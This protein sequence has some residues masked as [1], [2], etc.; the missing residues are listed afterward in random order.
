MP[1]GLLMSFNSKT[2]ELAVN[3]TSSM[4]GLLPDARDGHR[5]AFYRRARLQTAVKVGR[6][7]ANLDHRQGHGTTLVSSIYQSSG[8]RLRAASEGTRSQAVAA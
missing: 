2:D 5:H 7:I 3:V 8:T 1:I 4:R 6:H